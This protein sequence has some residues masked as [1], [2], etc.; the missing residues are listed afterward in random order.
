MLDGVLYALDE[1]A[2]DVL[3]TTNVVPADVWH[4]DNSNLAEGRGVGYAKS[5]AEVFHGD[6]QRIQDLC[7]DR[8]FVEIN[9]IHL[10]TD[11]LHGSLRAEGGNVGT[12]ITVSLGRN[13]LKIDIVAELHVLGVDLQDLQTSSWV[14]NANVDLTIETTETT[15]CRVDGVGTVGGSHD[16]NVG[17]CLHAVH[18]GQ[19]L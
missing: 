9:Q 19:E 11:L 16:D 4:L 5:E 8:V 12:D 15:K 18:E 3:E 14:R 17:A 13:G 1:L 10:L 6:T 2:L 7:I